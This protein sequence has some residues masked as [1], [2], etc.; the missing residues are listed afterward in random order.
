MLAFKESHS[1]S[2]QLYLKMSDL[3]EQPF[4]P[5]KVISHHS[6]ESLI[7]ESEHNERFFF[8]GTV[9]LS[10]S[11]SDKTG[12]FQISEGDSVAVTGKVRLADKA[13]LMHTT[14]PEEVKTSKF[15]P[16]S[17]DDIYKELRL[18]GYAYDGVFK[19]IKMADNEGQWA[20]IGWEENWVGFLDTM[21]QFPVVCKE[22][23]GLFIPTRLQSATINPSIFLDMLK[24]NKSMESEGIILKR[25]KNDECL[26]EKGD[27]N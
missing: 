1:W 11:I 16:L 18:Q 15:L 8:P 4:F 5:K 3:R 20:K 21:L 2:S 13:V 10:V 12:D 26:I 25:T 14:Q 6:Q 9:K 22:T 23:R 24:N 17:S 19:G 7:G 27:L